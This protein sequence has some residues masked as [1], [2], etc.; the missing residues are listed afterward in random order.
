MPIPPLS[1]GDA[2]LS[3]SALTLASLRDELRSARRWQDLLTEEDRR[4]LLGDIARTALAVGRDLHPDRHLSDLD[5]GDAA[6]DATEI[7]PRERVAFL[8]AAWPR[9]SPALSALEAEPAP[10]LVPGTR[11]VA[12]ERARRITPKDLLAAVRSGDL[13]PAPDAAVPLADAL[14][15]RLPR[16]VAERVALPSWDT[17]ANRAVKAMLA[18]W[19][20]DLGT[21]SALATV[22]G[23]SEVAARAERL[24]RRVRARLRHDPWRD[25]P[26]VPGAAVPPLPAALRAHGPHRLLHDT[27]RRY[28]RGFAFDWA[29]PLFT[30]PSRETWLLYEYWCLFRVAVALRDLGFRTTGAGDF[31]LSRAGL[32]FT[33]LK[34]TASRLTFRRSADSRTV[35]LTYNRAF[36]RAKGAGDTDGW[37]SR[38]HALRPDIVLESAGRLLVL[39]AKF[40]T[41]AAATPDGWRFQ[42]GA[43]FPD[44]QQMHTYRDALTYGAARGAVWGAWLLYCGRVDLDAPTVVAYPP[45]TEERPFGAGGVGAIRLRPNAE[46]TAL[47]ELLTAFFA[48]A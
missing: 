11:V 37:H 8:A 22:V 36:Q 28:R 30:L 32:T 20:R 2:P 27:W 44:I 40:K 7:S 39:D 25:L 47:R 6:D 21:A 23:A 35:T 24:R 48:E 16:R 14:G 5:L 31:R 26:L 38:S 29:N 1:E 12:F 46:S 45:P 9:L 34:G 43:L 42:E 15:G 19:S 4:A 10:A 17:P 18:Q 33:L 13:I 41:Y 3:S